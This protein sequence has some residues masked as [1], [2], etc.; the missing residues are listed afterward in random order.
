MCNKL[1]VRG[2]FWLSKPWVQVWVFCIT[3]NLKAC[4]ARVSS[5]NK[6]LLR[7]SEN[8]S[9]LAFFFHFC[10]QFLGKTFNFAFNF[11]KS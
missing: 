3:L 5:G 11:L 7:L 9:P 10:D 6:Q 8:M 1:S 2:W 4:S